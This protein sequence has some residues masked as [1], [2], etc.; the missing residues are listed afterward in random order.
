M[1]TGIREAARFGSEGILSPWLWVEETDSTRKG[2]RPRQFTVRR[3]RNWRAEM[4]RFVIL[5]Y[6]FRRA[7]GRTIANG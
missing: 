4:T 7:I 3:E 1:A 6:I 5:A 2:T